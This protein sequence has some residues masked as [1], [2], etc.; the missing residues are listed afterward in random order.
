MRIV[1]GRT[2]TD[3]EALASAGMSPVAIVSEN[4]ARRLFGAIDPIGRVILIPRTS[5]RAAYP[6]TVVGVAS[7]V[8]WHQV[9]DEPELFLYL[10]FNNPEFGV[11]SATLLVKS[12]QPPG[13]VI[14]RVEAAA[15]EVDPT[16]PVQ[17]SRALQTSIDRSQSDRRIFAW[18]LSM[19]GWLAFVLAAV[20]LY[21]LLAQSVAER[22]RE[23][24]IR[25]AIGGERVHIFMLVMRQA[26]WI[27]ALGTA[28][29]SGLAFLGS[30]LV[31]AQLYGVTR[32]DPAVYAAAAASL[33][34]VV[35]LAGLWPARTATR[36]EPVEALRV[37]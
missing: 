29:G 24:G 22:R 15:K 19:L 16:L 33:G 23:F 17:Y 28:L 4:L 11:R 3:E 34:A 1:R 8:H 2:F 9:T 7:D 21:C 13:E 35:L 12:P 18:V 27:G 36:I 31:E 6:L 20:G 5:R 32:V 25:M 14:R 30:R 26:L 37:E 10:P